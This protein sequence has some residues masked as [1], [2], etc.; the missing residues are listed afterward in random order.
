M[1]SILVA[2]LVGLFYL[3]TFATPT[4]EAC[5]DYESSISG[6][7]PHMALKQRLHE[8]LQYALPSALF[9]T[10]LLPTPFQ[11]EGLLRSKP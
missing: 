3:N 5:I 4:Y 11:S 6:N 8:P 9:P 7:F 10:A 1:R 2:G